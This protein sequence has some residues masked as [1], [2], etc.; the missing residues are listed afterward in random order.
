MNSCHNKSD[1]PSN[2]NNSGEALPERTKGAYKECVQAEPKPYNA[3]NHSNDRV[4]RVNHED[5]IYLLREAI[6]Y[7]LCVCLAVLFSMGLGLSFLQAFIVFSFLV[8]L[9]MAVNGVRNGIYIEVLVGAMTA[10]LALGWM[11]DWF[12]EGFH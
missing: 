11:I 2:G 3:Q 5:L 10:A 12:W 8:G 9:V 4:S 1:K 7:L 6:P